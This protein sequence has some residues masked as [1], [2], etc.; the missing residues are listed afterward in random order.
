M[1]SDLP[2]SLKLRRPSEQ[3]EK[4]PVRPK[5]FQNKARRERWSIHIEA[6]QRG[7]V[8]QAEYYR[9]FDLRRRN[10]R[11]RWLQHL[12]GEEATRELAAYQVELRRGVSIFCAS[13]YKS[14]VNLDSLL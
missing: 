5:Y 13:S 12:A 6:W 10:S 9:Q 11:T 14:F 1:P 3:V 7:G 8:S 4:S 2:P